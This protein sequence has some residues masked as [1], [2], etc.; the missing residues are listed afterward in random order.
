LRLGFVLAR[1]GDILFDH[2][3]LDEAEYVQHARSLALGHGEDRAYWQPP[4]L[5]YMLA[6][7][8]KVFGPGLLAPRILQVLASIGSCALAFAVARRLFDVRVAL[9]TAA[10]CALHGVLVYECYELL[11]A[12]WIVLFDLLALWLLLRAA[13]ARDP[14]WSFGAGLA[15]GVSAIFAP[16]ILPFVLVAAVVLRRPVPIAALVLGVLLPVV[17]VALR[18]YDHGGE[19]V[20]V[21]T[22]SGLNLYIGNNTDYRATF[23][24]RP[25]RDWEQLTSEPAR[26]GIPANRPGAWSAYFQHKALRF[27]VD[28]PGSA[29]ALA[30]RK[31]WLFLHGAEIP[32]DTDLYAARDES[33]L[34]G[35]L[36]WPRPVDVPDGLLI[37]A[38]LV[39]IAALWRERRRLVL[40]LALLATLAV[41]TAA[42]FVTARHRAPALPLFALFAAAGAPLAWQRW[43]V[44]AAI[45]AAVLVVAL[46]L[47]TWETRLSYPGELDFYRGL[48]A[49]AQRDVPAAR[50]AFQRAL[51]ANPHDPRFELELARLP[52]E[53]SP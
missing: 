47:P 31:L 1:H 26:H 5:V 33:W 3:A 2:P 53:G 14:L 44:H 50:A 10:I 40:P 12:T 16:T 21:S 24:V 51:A 45:A 7:T 28:E 17:P 9:V 38:A 39:G 46:N 4:G 48:A 19:I 23:S 25:G 6:A 15:V 29:L 20:P 49:E 27:V 42:F 22:N 43:R 52:P 37:P 41:V 34:L 13:E 36:V 8:F 35:A 11:P 30:A 18:N 32:R